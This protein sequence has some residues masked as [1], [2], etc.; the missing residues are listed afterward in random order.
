MPMLN[1]K[2]VFSTCREKAASRAD[3]QKRMALEEVSTTAT[4]GSFTTRIIG[5]LEFHLAEC[6]FAMQS[7]VDEG[8]GSRSIDP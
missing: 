1:L 8:I 6:V 5:W 4:K 2:K 7:D 3:G